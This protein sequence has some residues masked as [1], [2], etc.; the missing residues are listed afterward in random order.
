MSCDYV[1]YCTTCSS[2]H[3]FNDA[4]HQQ[5]LMRSLIRYASA[6]GHLAPLLDE[7]PVDVQTPYGRLHPEWF[8]E[9]AEHE[10]V[11]VD[12]YGRLENQCRANVICSHCTNIHPCLLDRDHD[13]DHVPGKLR[14]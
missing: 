9:H 6:I 5:D 4:N 2:R 8:A 11:V 7:A 10:L 14:W 12:E 13:G 1:V 3:P